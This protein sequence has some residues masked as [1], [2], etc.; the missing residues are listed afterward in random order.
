MIRRERD[1]PVR[2]LFRVR[3]VSWRG[4]AVADMAEHFQRDH[5]REVDV[6]AEQ[7]FGCLACHCGRDRGAPVAALGDVAG[8]SESLHQ[9][10]PCTRDA[11]GIPAGGAGLAREP[12]AR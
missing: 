11:V 9:H 4:I 12:V 5:L 3:Q 1:L 10:R 2:A 7:S 8:I 6:D